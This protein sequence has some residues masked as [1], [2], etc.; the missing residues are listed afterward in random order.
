MG[1]P[2]DEEGQ[3]PSVCS[4]CPDRDVLCAW[5]PERHKLQTPKSA[6]KEV[7]TGRWLF[8]AVFLVSF[9]AIMAT[10]VAAGA[11]FYLIHITG[12]YHTVSVGKNNEIIGIINNHSKEL[13]TT[14]NDSA[15]T[16][17]LQT[18][19]RDALNTVVPELTAGQNMILA[20]F[21]W[22]NC[23]TVSHSTATCGPPPKT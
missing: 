3:A 11:V 5:C 8:L 23:M 18:Q 9:Y 22:Q 19:V 1:P 16:K 2:V 20:N 15:T 7:R 4:E 12:Q 10:T 17:K 13:S 14:K 21:A 6:K